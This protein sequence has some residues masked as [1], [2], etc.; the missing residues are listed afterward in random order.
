MNTAKQPIYLDIMHSIKNKI[1]KNEYPTGYKFTEA[2]LANDFNCSRITAKRALDEL[3]QEGL[4]ERRKGSGS[5]L[6][7]LST[8]SEVEEGK[9]ITL[10]FPHGYL[11]SNLMTYFYGSSDMLSTR[12]YVPAIIAGSS[13]T[14]TSEELISRAVTNGCAG[15]IFYPEH[16]SDTTEM[17]T[18]LAVEDFPIVVIDKHFH[19][20]PVNTVTSDNYEGARAAI[21]LLH[22]NGHRNIAF[23][24][25]HNINTRSTI[26]D[27]F[28][29][30]AMVHKANGLKIN[31]DN[32]ISGFNL[33][34]KES[35]PDVYNQVIGILPLAG[36]Q[37]DF[38]E[39]IITQLIN[40]GVTA[41]VG[42]NDL[43]AMY[44][45]KTCE[46][47]GLSVPE[48]LSIVGFDDH[49]LLQH[50]GVPITTVRQDFYGMGYRA[51]ELLMK[52]IDHRT[53]PAE[54]IVMPVEI[55]ERT[56]IKTLMPD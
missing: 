3:T 13:D 10:I 56:S 43:V 30:Y 32:V 53:M 47:M 24:S 34:L 18:T 12:G 17:L 20:I 16:N 11:A 23:V 39:D 19:G 21:Q 5:Y 52:K 6:A 40:R 37:H 1:N 2:A 9:N 4:I 31:L 8:R 51:A 50:M 27:R 7:D 44:M 33:T 38:F 29:G 48:D 28:L 35:Y 46:N 49:I 42:S 54:T 25:D 14:V 45:V 15:I 22:D 41:I 26:K 36:N 55:V